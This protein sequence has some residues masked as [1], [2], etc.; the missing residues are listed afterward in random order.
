MAVAGF[1]MFVIAGLGVV[2]GMPV[3]LLVGPSTAAL[4]IL[5][6]FLPLCFGWYIATRADDVH[7]IEAAAASTFI[8]GAF[9]TGL[10]GMYQ[11][12][13][14]PL[15]DIN[16]MQRSGMTTIGRPVPFEV[17]VFGTMHSPGIL[18]SF[19]VIPLVLWLARPRASSMLAA[20]V[21]GVALLL[22]QVRSAWLAVAVAAVFVF[23][24]LNAVQRVR[25][26]VLTLAAVL[27]S[28]A[29]LYTP[30]MRELVNSRMQT[31]ERLEEDY[32]AMARVTGHEMALDFVAQN[33]L[34]AG[35]GQIDP[36]TEQF[37]SMRDS[38]LA[39]TLVQFG[40]PG[41][42]LYLA[43]IG[44]LGD[45]AVRLLLVGRQHPGRGPGRGRARPAGQ[46]H[47]ERGH[48]RTDRCLPVD[49]RRPGSGRS[50]DA[51]AAAGAR[52]PAPMAALPAARFRGRVTAAGAGMRTPMLRAL[53]IGC[54]WPS[55]HGGGGDRVFAELAR[56]LPGKGIG[57]EALF[58]G[59]A[60][61]DGSMAATLSSFGEVSDGT[62]ARWL[63]ARR[64]LAARAASG[65]FDLV[66]SHFALY[67]SAAAGWLRR[68]PHVVHFHG[69]WAA[70]SRQEGGG[71]LSALAKWSVERAVYRTADRFIVLSQ[72]FAALATREYGVPP[73]QIRVVPGSADLQR[74]QVAASR[75]EARERLGWPQDRRVIVVGAAAGAPHR[76][77][78]ADRGDA[79]DRRR[80]ARC[81]ALHRRH[82]PAAPG[83]APARP[84]PGPG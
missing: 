55:E 74:F 32:S 26:A 17:R 59:A 72:A 41:T 28:S 30:E 10:Y 15:W 52:L 75:P 9:V 24:A 77:G 33:P 18:A 60:S 49:D 81:G 51:A 57:L 22:S 48:R 80:P 68:V 39:A 56:Y 36:K 82:R 14:P 64:A 47:L 37:I 73:A 65:Q 53:Q 69:P 31:M 61:V 40:L 19:L 66:A 42:L 38:V 50:G 13:S 25:M 63:G 84:G 11:F 46:F 79:G 23:G 45:G 78:P 5:N 20:G 8:A 83:A 2:F 71:R 54:V 12:V 67:A 6:W 70:E 16:W 34:G 3:G 62:R 4:E 44:G 76:R 1:G 35:I 7:R 43:A 21:A 27:L 58:A 29:A